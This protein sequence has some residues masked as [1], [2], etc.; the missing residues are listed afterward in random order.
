MEILAVIALIGVLLLFVMPNL[1]KIFSNSINSTMKAQE[2]EIEDISL[3]YLDDY[4][5]NK[6]PGRVCPSSLT[7]NSDNTY[8]GYVELQSLEEYTDE[9]SLQGTECTGCV[10]FTNN[11][12][13]AYLICGE[14][15]T[16]KTDVDFRNICNLN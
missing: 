13:K 7:R 8:S 3:L 4:C 9:V 14:G 11:K 2:N 15:Y 16:T 6:L 12:P 10:I 1:A 5:R